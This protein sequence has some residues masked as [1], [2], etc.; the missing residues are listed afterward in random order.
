MSFVGCHWWSPRPGQVVIASIGCLLVS[1]CGREQPR[2]A[3]SL[4]ELECTRLGYACTWDQVSD[5]ALERSLELLSL[6][7]ETLS[8]GGRLLR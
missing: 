7:R 8:G 6:A 5:D 3:L 4:P 1:A 2:L